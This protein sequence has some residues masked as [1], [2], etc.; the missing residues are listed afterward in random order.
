MGFSK[1]DF[2]VVEAHERPA[3][4]GISYYILDCSGNREKAYEN[5]KGWETLPL[6]QNIS[7][8][9]YGGEIDGMMYSGDISESAHIPKIKH[10]YYCFIDKLQS[11]K[12]KHSDAELLDSVSFNF[13]LAIY[14]ADTDMLYYM[15][16]V[17]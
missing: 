6:S 14:D 1:N 9:L 3:P 11:G 15:E 10:G 4:E 7:V 8:L 5:M 13:R 2:I 16:L 12:N 17:T